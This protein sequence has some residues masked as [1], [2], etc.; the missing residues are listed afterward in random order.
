MYVCPL[1]RAGRSEPGGVPRGEDQWTGVR[2][3][4]KGR[5]PAVVL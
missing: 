1:A 3:Q 4:A 5:T 2:G